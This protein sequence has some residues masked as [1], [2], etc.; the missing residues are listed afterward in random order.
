MRQR[1]SP[2]WARRWALGLSCRTL[3]VWRE[4]VTGASTNYVNMTLHLD[5]AAASPTAT[6][7]D[8]LLGVV[9]EDGA[10]PD[11]KRDYRFRGPPEGQFSRSQAKTALQVVS[12]QKWAC[13]RSVLSVEYSK[14]TTSQ[15]CKQ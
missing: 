14:E 7:A 11:S 4:D 8:D 2:H 3:V 13:R 15:V 1:E 12:P 9:N 10:G 6:T 5:D